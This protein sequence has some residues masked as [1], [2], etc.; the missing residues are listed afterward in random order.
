[1]P[2]QINFFLSLSTFYELQILKIE[3]MGVDV[4]GC[5]L[6]R[7]RVER[8]TV[9]LSHP[10]GG[11]NYLLGTKEL[12]LLAIIIIN[13]NE[14]RSGALRRRKQVCQLLAPV[15]IMQ[16]RSFQSCISTIAFLS[17]PK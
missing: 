6:V 8:V 5:G 3:A 10:R 1:M 13:L 9:F 2:S 11:N 15:W 16:W 14:V 4:P 17:M 12:F 7:D